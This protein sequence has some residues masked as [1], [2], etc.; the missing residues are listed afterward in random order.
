MNTMTKSNLFKKAH[1]MTR[2]VINTYPE[3][4]YHVTFS[5][6]LKALYSK[7]TYEEI[8]NDWKE[9]GFSIRRWQKYGKDRLYVDSYGYIDL[10]SNEINAIRPGKSTQLRHLLDDLK[11]IA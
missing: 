11:T 6:A 10:N 1:E 9:C 4:N 2:E 5:A 7:K 3:A 8:I